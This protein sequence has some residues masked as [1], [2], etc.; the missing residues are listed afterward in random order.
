MT[1]LTD[2]SARTLSGEMRHLSDFAGQVVLV[3][4]VAS[5]CGFTPQYLALEDLWQRRR[6][7]G[8]AVL[9]FPCNQFARQEP[10]TDAQI[11]DFCVT[12]Y[13]VTFPVFAKVDVN[14]RDAHPLW[15]WMRRSRRGRFGDRVK[16][17]FTK[18]LIGAD[19]LVIDRYA[20]IVRPESIEADIV[21]ALRG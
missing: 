1:T 8:F 5:R 20:P 15:Q 16:W 7:Q 2:F 3:V 6:H 13:D 4:N 19:G 9:G 17:N 18:F 11:R 10:G 12:V 14:G 21:T